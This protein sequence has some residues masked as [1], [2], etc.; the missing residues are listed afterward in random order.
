MKP[1]SLLVAAV[2]LA[3]LSGAVW[4]AKRHPASTAATSS[5]TPAAPKLADIPDGQVK[6][7]SLSKKAALPVTLERQGGKWAVT[8]P[9]H[10]AADQDAVSSVASALSP[11]TGDSVVEDRPGDVSKYGLT[12]PSLVVDVTKTNG[13]S[14]KIVF[15]DDLPAGSLVYAQHGSD[16]K[17]YA[18]SS[19]VR[20]SFDKTLNDL[21]DK[22]LLT[23]DSNKL[24]SLEV[25]SGK[26]DIE[27]HKNNQNDWQITK[28]SPYRADGFQVEEL[29]RKLTDAKMDLAGSADNAKKVE[30]S[31][32]SGQAL[33]TVKVADAS[34]QQSLD[35]RK[36]K[37]DYF[38]KS[39]VVT[40]A[41]KVSSDLGKA[42]EKSLD[43]FRNKK[44]F[45]FGF[46]DP[47]KVQV[48]QGGNDKSYQKV[49]SDWK[50]NGK[51]IDAASIQ[52]FI[53]KLRDLSAAK[54]VESGFANPVFEITVNSN[55]GKRVE[56]VSLSK[57]IDGY[58]AKRE[59]ESA[60]Y[61]LDSKVVDDLIK[62][63]RDIKEAPPAKK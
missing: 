36:N 46:N 24:T 23:F 1:R 39:S 43:D 2:L 7:I 6:Q 54:F 25:L 29:I 34:G 38:A 18:V 53:D 16:P 28:P 27:F 13:K 49:G 61:Q 58:I 19:S 41:Y 51:T 56:K 55:E 20:S 62:A 26:S 48:Q 8:S 22:R 11:V 60:L 37:D 57:T 15:G 63:S 10:L 3:A 42:V 47:T 32:S 5:S 33:A 12:N 30:S 31:F 40:G 52:A 45:D 21:R 35:L 50:L 59:N 44:L 17:V 14:E 9:D 4:Y